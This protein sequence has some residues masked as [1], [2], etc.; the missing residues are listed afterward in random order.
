M[1]NSVGQ[2]KY[3]SFVYYADHLCSDIVHRQCLMKVLNLIAQ[4]E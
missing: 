3:V 2:G 4:S 1:E